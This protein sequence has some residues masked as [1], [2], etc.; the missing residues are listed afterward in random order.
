MSLAGITGKYIFRVASG[1]S[2]IVNYEHKCVMWHAQQKRYIHKIK[3]AWLFIAY[4]PCDM[5]M[6]MIDRRWRIDVQE[7]YKSG[8]Q[9]ICFYERIPY[10]WSSSVGIHS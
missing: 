1:N 3:I 6:A 4:C 2:G 10:F 8:E 9:R 5:R 7:Y